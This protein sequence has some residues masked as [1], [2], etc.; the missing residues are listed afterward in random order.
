MG[1][2]ISVMRVIEYYAQC[3]FGWNNIETIA[4]LPPTNTNSNNKNTD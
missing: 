1:E 3:D 4:M 2:A